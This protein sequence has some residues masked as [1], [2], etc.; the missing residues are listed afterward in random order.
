MS[1]HCNKDTALKDSHTFTLET[2]AGHLISVTERPA[3]NAKATVIIAPAMGVP[4]RYYAA[5]AAWLVT[6]GFHVFTFDYYGMADSSV[7]N[8]RRLNVN[9]IDWAEQD[10]EQ[11]I[12]YVA[13]Q[14]PALPIIW[15]A[16]SVGGQLFGALSN[17][18]LVSKMVTVTTG[19]GYWLEN[20]PALKRKSWLL[21]FFAVPLTLPLFGYFPG[22]RL[23][24]VDDLPKQVMR[25][26]RKWCLH[27]DYL[28]GVEGPQ[29]RDKFAQ[30]K[31]PITSL[32]VTD[33]ELL[34]ARNIESL[35]SFYVNAP[36]KMVR[37]APQDINAK[38]IGHFGFFR[39]QF[40]TSLWQ[41]YLLPELNIQNSKEKG[42]V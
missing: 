17:H 19:S 28:I 16:H 21:W 1:N 37:I 12:E 5:I 2:P 34:S 27:K 36:L 42:A 23:K 33:D 10:C 3:N 25:Q 6:Q 38:R 14:R 20:S 26:W 22:K 7:A 13:A 18:H 4:Q 41:N 39:A 24:M 30:V 9:I 32:S 29:L 8:I 35:H 40:E 31:T 11:V 15:L